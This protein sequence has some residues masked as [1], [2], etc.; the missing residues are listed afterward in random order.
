MDALWSTQAPRVPNFTGLF[1]NIHTPHAFRGYSRRMPGPVATLGTPMFCDMGFAPSALLVEP[2]GVFAND[3]PVATM[4]DFAPMVNI[5]T[6]GLCRSPAN[7]DVIALTAAALG[8]PTPAPC[9][10]VVV[11]PWISPSNVLI[12]GMPVLTEGA[13]CEVGPAHRPKIILNHP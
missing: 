11:T 12:D 8:V 7:P 6:F 10:P 4:M 5:P 13:A 2:L 1:T 9:I 3:L